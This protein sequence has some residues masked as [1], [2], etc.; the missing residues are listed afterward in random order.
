MIITNNEDSN[1]RLLLSPVEIPPKY[2]DF[3]NNLDVFFS[4]YEKK[5]PKQKMSDIVKGAFFAMRSE[6]RNNPDWMSQAS[7]SL[8]EIIYPLI[9]TD[10]VHNTIR[11]FYRSIKEISKLSP[12]SFSE[13]VNSESFVSD[14]VMVDKMY[15][16]LSD[17]TH[18]GVS[19]RGFESIDKFIEFT[20]NDYNKLVDDYINL[21]NRIVTIQQIYVHSFIDY[22]IQNIK[23]K[24]HKNNLTCH[25]RNIINLNYDARNYFYSK[26]D[27]KWMSWLW[28]K[29]FLD[30]IKKKSEDLTKY[31]YR[32]PELNYISRLVSVVPDTVYKIIMNVKIS[33]ET[34]NP[35]VID[36]F[37]R[38]CDVFSAEQLKHIVNKIDKEKWIELMKSFNHWGFEYENMFHALSDA[39]DYK[40]IITLAKSVLTVVKKEEIKKEPHGFISNKVFYFSD[41]EFTKVFHYML[42]IDNEH[43]EE[44]ISLCCDVMTEIVL[45]GDK[46]Y[47]SVF[48]YSENFHLFDVDFF[49]LKTNS[50]RHT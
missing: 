47:K 20:E 48:K 42:R 34:F 41:L 39:G 49:T 1:I 3:L 36:Q 12:D 29:G 24:N 13:Q 25:I 10:S 14:F 11:V 2:I 6:C 37:S 15:Q 50:G 16:R 28:E 9:S 38:I 46:T 44:A 31:S 27:K 8:R 23:G 17:L 40:S 19:V 30:I 26:A 32:T 35:E 18:H 45:L 4:S 21:M 33:K 22:I 5:S 43:L 7:N